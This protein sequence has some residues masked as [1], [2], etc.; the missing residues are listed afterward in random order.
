MKKVILGG[1]LML[2]GLISAV[3]LMAGTMIVTAIQLRPVQFPPDVAYTIF[4]LRPA[5]FIVSFVIFII[6]FAIGLILSLRGLF[7]K[8]D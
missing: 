4:P 6:V 1:M 2:A 8:R 3:I 7:E 5:I